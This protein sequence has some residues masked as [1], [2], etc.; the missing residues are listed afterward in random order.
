MA[1]N[2]PYVRPY[3]DA[4]IF[5]SWLKG[6]DEGPLFDGTR[7]NR[8]PVSLHAM[9]GAE[10]GEYP[11]VTSHFSMAEVF[12][13]KSDGNERLT[14]EQNGRIMR[15]FNESTWLSWVELDW[16]VG[17]LANG[18][19]VR[20]RAEGLRPHDAVHLASALRAKCDVLLTWDG[21]LLK[22]KHEGIR[23]EFPRFY[24]VKPAKT[25]YLFDAADGE[26][27]SSA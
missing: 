16:T 20:F 9:E 22:V 25:G 17:E 18:L 14:D 6:T 23:I 2:A 27:D 24:R 7:G 26:T 10:N 19:L 8:S 11:M 13:K 3:F 1:T 12:K 21:P 5:I 4:A 15:Y